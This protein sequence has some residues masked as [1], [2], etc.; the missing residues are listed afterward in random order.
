MSFMLGAANSKKRK[1]S[2]S[3]ITSLPIEVLVT[4]SKRKGSLSLDIELSKETWNL[5]ITELK[6]TWQKILFIKSQ[7]FED[8]SG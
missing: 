8:D 2:I 3:V 4:D 5:A 6:I 1:L 7:F